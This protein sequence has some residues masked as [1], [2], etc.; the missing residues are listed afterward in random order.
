MARERT[1]KIGAINI[2]MHAPHSPHRYVQMMF[3]VFRQQRMVRLGKVYG[4]MLGTVYAT[5]RDRPTLGLSGEIYRFLKLDPNEPWFNAATKEVATEGELR[6]IRIPEHLLP[7]LQ[8]IP[9]VFRP[10]SHR[11]YFAARDRQDSLGPLVAQRLF[12]RLLAP[13]TNE[14][15]YPTIEVTVMPDQDSIERILNMPTLEKLSIRLVRPNPDDGDD[16]QAR[17]LAKM[18][19]QRTRR[20]ELQLVAERNGTI[21]P[22][23]ET[24]VMARVAANNGLVYASGRD[25]DGLPIQESTKE[26][27]M[28][29]PATVDTAIETTSDVM[30]RMADSLDAR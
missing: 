10:R 2:A 14:L 4:A 23:Q 1:I 13:L 9:F 6:A 21:E 12:E 29:V 22:D 16:D 17:W 7:H 5:Q 11:L 25:A 28:L 24:K 27:P 18:E 8:R 19:K 26:K 30:N 15:G 3:E 20:M